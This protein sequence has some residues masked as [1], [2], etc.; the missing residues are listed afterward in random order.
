MSIFIFAAAVGLFIFAAFQYGA[1]IYRKLFGG[2]GDV[3]FE[4]AKTNA[5]SEARSAVTVPDIDI[6][7][8]M[9]KGKL[10][11]YNFD[12]AG[13]LFVRMNVGDNYL[14]ARVEGFVNQRERFLIN[15][16]KV[17]QKASAVNKIDRSI[18]DPNAE[19]TR[20]VFVSIASRRQKR[21]CEAASDGTGF[22]Q[23]WCRFDSKWPKLTDQK[24]FDLVRE[25]LAGG[26]N[27]IFPENVFIFLQTNFLTGDP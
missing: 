12:E 6:P 18:L 1:D 21:D 11:A 19:P 13:N 22:S 23:R 10:A 15:D 9:A 2:K 16:M 20:L 17:E 24:L 5:G 14:N 7:Y 25:S 27:F 4:T 26:E 8:V 3:E